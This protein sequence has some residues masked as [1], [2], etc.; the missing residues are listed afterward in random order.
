MSDCAPIA[1]LAEM[2]AILADLPGPVLAAGTAAALREAQLT[3][4][5]GAL[6]RLEEIAHWMAT[7]QGRHPP[8]ATHPRT[9]VF[10]ANDQMALGLIHAF[11]VA[12]L[13][14][15][16]DISV[17]GFDD[18]PESAHFWPPLTTVRQDFGSL[19]AR[20]VATL[21][22]TISR[23]DEPAAPEASISP[24]VE[25]QLIIRDSVATV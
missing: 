20:C 9:A 7:W 15:P 11:R 4:P 1:T 2:R 13:D 12:G 18:I 10:A 24:V 5:R 14:V 8:T 21:L 23:E 25:P 16:R 3:K 19:G 6:G 22:D 17:V